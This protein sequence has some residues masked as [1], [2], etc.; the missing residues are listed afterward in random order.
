MGILHARDLTI[1]LKNASGYDKTGSALPSASFASGTTDIYVKEVSI[2]EGEKAFDQQDYTGEDANGYQNQAKIW[3]PV[4]KVSVEMKLD[5]DGLTALRALLYDTVDTSSISGY[6]RLQNG[7]AARR[8]VDVLCLI[9][10]GTDEAEF[11]VLQ[12]EQTAPET[13]LVGV[14][15]QFEYSVMLEALA[16]DID[17]VFKD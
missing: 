10:D 7:N 1:K 9:T 11:V 4:G 16:K 6:T 13:N 15:G 14:D 2:K 17:V 5:E 3:K 8:N 12:A